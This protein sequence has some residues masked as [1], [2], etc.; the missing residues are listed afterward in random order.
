MCLDRKL[1]LAREPTIHGFVLTLEG[2]FKVI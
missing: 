1:A 2:A